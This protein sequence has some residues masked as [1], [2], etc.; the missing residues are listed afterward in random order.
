VHHIGRYNCSMRAAPLSDKISDA[1]TSPPD[2]TIPRLL[3]GSNGA[4]GVE[5]GRQ[6]L[7]QRTTVHGHEGVTPGQI[8][9]ALLLYTEGAPT[10]GCDPQV[11]APASPGKTRIAPERPRRLRPAQSIT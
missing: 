9:L 6:M 1:L 10:R 11:L 2:V 8:A 4:C 3:A 5:L 7:R